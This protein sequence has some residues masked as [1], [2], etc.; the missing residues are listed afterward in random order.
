MSYNTPT[1]TLT[2]NIPRF[3]ISDL[4]KILNEYEKKNGDIEIDFWDQFSV[5]RY[6]KLKDIF[7][8]NNKVLLIG[9]F[10]VNGDDFID[11]ELRE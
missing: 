2:S 3:H 9:G 8:L 7:N 1:P 10:H 4:I 11:M 5:V 6:R